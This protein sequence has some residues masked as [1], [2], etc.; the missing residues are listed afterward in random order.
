MQLIGFD[1]IRKFGVNDLYCST[2]VQPV[3]RIADTCVDIVLSPN[4]CSLPALACLPVSYV[5]GGTT[6]EEIPLLR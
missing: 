2:I 1:G 5:S 3:E 6:R 4:R